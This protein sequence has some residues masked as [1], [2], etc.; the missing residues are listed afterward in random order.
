VRNRLRLARSQ[1]PSPRGVLRQHLAQQEHLVPAVHDRLADK[2]FGSTVAIHFGGV[3]QRHPKVDAEPH[4][5]DLVG[6]TARI[7][8]KMP[9]ALA[10]HRNLIPRR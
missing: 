4:R 8:G 10:E 5:G 2:H 6:A 7:L 3:D 1:G 9:G